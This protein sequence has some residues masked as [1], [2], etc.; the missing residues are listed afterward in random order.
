MIDNS[1]SFP[2]SLGVDTSPTLKEAKTAFNTLFD[3][4]G[5]LVALLNKKGSYATLS[6]RGKV[7]DTVKK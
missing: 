7:L 4:G 1:Y 3:A 6:F 2:F 5:T